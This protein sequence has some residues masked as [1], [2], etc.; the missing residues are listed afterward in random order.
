M[1]NLRSYQTEAI[2]SIYAY[3]A[4]EDKP[5]NPVVAMP[6]GTGKSVVIGGFA[7]SAL[8]QWPQTRIM[9]VT[10]VKE[11][12]Q[13]NY[14]KLVAMWPFAPAGV[15][16]AGLKSRDT[17]N[18]IIFAG[19]QSAAPVWPLFG[20]ID[21]LIIDEC[22]LLSPEENSNYQKLIRGLKSINPNLKVVGFTATKYRLGYGEITEPDK[23]GNK[24]L[25]DDVCF[26][27]TYLEAFNRLIAEGYLSPLVPKPMNTE[28]NVDGV[29][30]TAGDYNLKQL[31]VAVNKSTVTRAA[32]TEALQIAADRK[33]WLIF[34]SG[35]EHAEEI[36]RTM[37]EMGETC[38]AVHSKL[39]E[40]ERDEAI[41]KFQRGE[42]RALVNNNI[43]TTG[44]DSPWVDCIVVLRPTI[45]TVLW[46]QMLGRGTRPYD[47]TQMPWAQYD[48]EV[49][50]NCLVLDFAGNTRKLGPIN[51]PVVPRKKGEGGGEAP[52]KLCEVCN[53]F[54]HASVRI[55]SCCGS[56]FQFEVK[57]KDQ[58][59]SI[60]IIKGD[61]PITRVYK[62]SQIT[63]RVHKK[64]GRPDCLKLN[65]FTGLKAFDDYVLFEHPGV[66]QQKARRW[67]YERTDL[68]VPATVAEALENL[69]AIRSPTHINVWINPPEG[70][71]KILGYCYD[72]TAFGKEA[73]SE[74]PELLIDKA[75]A[76][77]KTHL[78][79]DDI[80]F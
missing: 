50:K 21:L 52:V 11:L 44:F 25:F 2:E 41:R 43:L 29:R 71:P 9:V 80:P 3:F 70:Y 61:A 12:I 36:A 19:V 40:E 59:S 51:D 28:L 5:G 53:T 66:M 73:P 37:N 27:I 18:N 48:K 32:L 46:V 17:K 75:P 55:C 67:W 15:Y 1:I 76:P 16:S 68:P 39:K 6:T 26:D 34:A 13:Q 57:I 45:S 63:A 56:E 14:A 64:A 23:D 24:A 54:N 8:H 33:H 79:D 10:H 38:L 42:V 62:V 4:K 58:A 69:P 35:V 31:Q 65:Y 22:H 7:M 77:I 60:D 20:W 47:G 78:L 30:K 49:K 74:G 72:G